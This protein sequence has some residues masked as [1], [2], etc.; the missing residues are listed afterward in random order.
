MLNGWQVEKRVKTKRLEKLDT[1]DTFGECNKELYGI[2]LEWTVLVLAEKNKCRRQALC[3]SLG[4]WFLA[5]SCSPFRALLIAAYLY[6]AA[7]HPQFCACC[8][9]MNPKL[10]Q[11]P[12]WYWCIETYW[13]LAEMK[14]VEAQL[15]RCLFNVLGID[16]ACARCVVRQ[17]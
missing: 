3:P 1:S 17:P 15:V 6:T 11:I 7:Q 8:R 4:L 14:S 12:T 5:F 9:L 2:T 10:I 16:F 13:I